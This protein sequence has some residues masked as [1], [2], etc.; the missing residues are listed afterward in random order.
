MTISI[1][2]DDN[3][4]EWLTRVE[5]A[6]DE[7]DQSEV[8]KNCDGSGV[9]EISKIECEFC[10]GTGYEERDEASNEKGIYNVYAHDSRRSSTWKIKNQKEAWL[11]SKRS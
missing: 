1:W 5:I 7:W 8:C 2:G 11:E 4:D 6:L 9:V 10:F 3:I